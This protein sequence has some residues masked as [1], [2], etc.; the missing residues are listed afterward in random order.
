MKKK[1][2]DLQIL[3]DR[4]NNEAFQT[5]SN[6]YIKVRRTSSIF[7]KGAVY[8]YYTCMD[9]HDN[10]F[11]FLCVVTTTNYKLFSLI[12]SSKFKIKSND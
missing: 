12:V 5:L 11:D 7:S 1:L 6:D 8:S 2:N 9:I 10:Y 3:N 4:F